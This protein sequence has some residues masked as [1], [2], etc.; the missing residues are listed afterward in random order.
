MINPISN[1]SGLILAHSFCTNHKIASI[2]DDLN[3]IEEKLVHKEKSHRQFFKLINR[4]HN[5]DV[6]FENQIE[7]DSYFDRVWNIVEKSN[8]RSPKAYTNLINC[9]RKYNVSMKFQ[10]ILS[11]INAHNLNDNK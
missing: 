7:I 8:V 10:T 2:R 1:I 4:L 5:E 3:S 9:M 11:K 6:N